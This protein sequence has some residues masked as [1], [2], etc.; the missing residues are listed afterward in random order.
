MHF[1]TC[2]PGMTEHCSAVHITYVHA[3]KG[4]AHWCVCNVGFPAHFQHD[5]KLHVFTKEYPECFEPCRLMLSTYYL[6]DADTF[7]GAHTI[8]PGAAV[9]GR[10]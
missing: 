7:H 3:K 10:I 2:L 8:T 5:K 6:I 1:D 9:L 4:N